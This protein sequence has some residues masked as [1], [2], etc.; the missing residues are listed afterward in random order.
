MS[1]GVL[2]D[3]SLI[4]HHEGLDIVSRLY[5]YKGEQKYS[6]HNTV[7]LEALDYN[8]KRAIIAASISEG[9]IVWDLRHKRLIELSYF[10][11]G[12]FLQL[13][14][15][16]STN[17]LYGVEE[18]SS[19][20]YEI[21]LS[22]GIVKIP[23][24]YYASKIKWIEKRREW[25]VG[26]GNKTLIY[27]QHFNP[28]DTV[29]ATRSLKLDPDMGLFSVSEDGEWLITHSGDPDKCSI[30]LWARNPLSAIYTFEVG[31]SNQVLEDIGISPNG[32]YC[33]V[34]TSN[35][36]FGNYRFSVYDLEDKKVIHQGYGQRVLEFWPD[37]DWLQIDDKTF[38]LEQKKLLEPLPHPPSIFGDA[39][40]DVRYQDQRLVYIDYQ[41]DTL[42]VMDSLEEHSGIIP[43]G[44]NKIA[45]ICKNEIR[46]YD[47]TESSPVSIIA[48]RYDKIGKVVPTY[49]FYFILN[50]D[51]QFMT[52]KSPE[53]LAQFR[54]N[55]NL[56]G[57]ELIEQQLNRPDLILEQLGF[58]DSATI[59]LYRQ[60]WEKK[61]ALI[62]TNEMDLAAPI[63]GAYSLSIT[64]RKQLPLLSD[65]S[66]ISLNCEIT[67]PESIPSNTLF[68]SSRV[69]GVPSLEVKYP[70]DSEGITNNFE[71]PL[72]EG[73]NRVEIYLENEYGQALAS[74]SIAVE[75]SGNT[76]GIG[77]LFIV[78]LGAAR[79][80]QS[81]Y[82]LTYP[83]KDVRDFA[84]FFERSTKNEQ[85]QTLLLT[86]TALTRSSL[87]QVRNFL[88]EAK[89][90]DRL[91]FLYSGHGMLTADKELFL[92]TWDVD[93][94]APQFNGIA[95]TTLEALLGECPAR[96]KV[97]L[98]DAC[99]SGWSDQGQAPVFNNNNL[100]K[101]VSIRSTYQA[102]ESDPISLSTE[103]P[104]EVMDRLF[105][106][107]NQDNGASLIT[108]AAGAEF[109]VELE[110][111]ENGLFTYTFLEGLRT[112]HADYN[113]D[114]QI[115]ISEIKRYVE[116]MV[117]ERSGGQQRPTSRY[118]NPYT[119]FILAN[120]KMA[121]FG[122]LQQAASWGNL[123]S[124]RQLLEVEGAN[125][126][127]RDKY[128]FTALHYAARDDS[129]Q[130]VELLISLG[131]DVNAR[132]ESERTPLYLA[133][134]NDNRRCARLL[135]KAGASK[136]AYL[137]GYSPFKA[138]LENCH[139]DIAEYIGPP[140]SLS[141]KERD[142]NY[143]LLDI[144]CKD[145][146]L[147][148]KM[149]LEPG[150]DPD[151]FYSPYSESLL[152]T[153]VAIGREDI[154]RQLL[155]LGADPDFF[156]TGHSSAPLF[157][158]V[159]GGRIEFVKLLLEA[160]ANPSCHDKDGWTP[161]M[162]AIQNENL[163]IVKLLLKAGADPNHTN[164]IFGGTALKNAV[165]LENTKLIKMLL[166]AGADPN[167]E[168]NHGLS[169]YDY[170]QMKGIRVKR[171]L[172]FNK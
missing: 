93:F 13:E 162:M 64:N 120:Y 11:T 127:S 51:L 12:H 35:N 31:E 129:P 110:E 27:D 76:Q 98:I 40:Y 52:I 147:L 121:D 138:A 128:G 140:D 39:D 22:K 32:K 114:R 168:D 3:K 10:E 77:R 87:R 167:L 134:Y 146:E 20:I 94:K 29:W 105:S 157:H 43:I 45:S 37:Q 63:S 136:K 62:N 49:P 59:Q 30:K 148:Q 131:A 144:K 132:G 159:D 133:A 1:S 17:T 75:R 92:G 16:E 156:S 53:D 103:S 117:V 84:H 108:A 28:K 14:W 61:M 150:F 90:E 58:A 88:A 171:L 153:A 33:W 81:A 139:T 91:L 67:A 104:F 170:A 86:D 155:A 60:A 6:I 68:L 18:G 48:A 166:R 36:F 99:H 111:Y 66:L 70:V 15:Q 154:C 24:V 125:V 41:Q 78:G 38:D 57:F 165:N 89:T 69:N 4:V 126:N 163:E 82:N 130:A 124:I 56:L 149:S 47:N 85:L 42:I 97:L 169:P 116:E 152:A 164:N 44:K 123:T 23:K 96:E 83:A 71:V 135:L 119:D 65:A 79:Y 50:A 137:P 122:L 115:Q 143:L 113:K 109:A 172:R 8:P 54:L 55:D 112:L 7:S 72:S 102:D 46:I 118:T 26:Q 2:D 160:G 161:L 141:E 145:G 34:S 80:Q 151:L 107:I 74:T 106:F 100:G 21:D 101:G 73:M 9:L 142:F 25:F 5:H 95:I 19:L 158:A